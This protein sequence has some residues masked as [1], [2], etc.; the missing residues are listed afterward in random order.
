M[1]N[2]DPTKLA[3]VTSIE[4]ASSEQYT[5]GK[6]QGVRVVEP[7]LVALKRVHFVTVGWA[8]EMWMNKVQEMLDG[9]TEG[10]VHEGELEI[11]IS[12][13]WEGL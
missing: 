12:D 13:K 11:T 10:R 2:Y 9:V 5:W 1:Q 4:C 3:L 6:E 7:A 8:P